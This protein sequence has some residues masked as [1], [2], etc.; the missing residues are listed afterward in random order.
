MGTVRG[1]GL[2]ALG[3][4]SRGGELCVVECFCCS[5]VDAGFVLFCTE[6]FTEGGGNACDEHSCW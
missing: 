4:S 6:V 1:R 2:G 3:M 5:F